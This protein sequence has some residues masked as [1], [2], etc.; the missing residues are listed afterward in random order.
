MDATIGG[1]VVEA[2]AGVV[3]AVNKWDLASERES[4]GARLRARACATI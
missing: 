3:V 1:E 4:E 2:G